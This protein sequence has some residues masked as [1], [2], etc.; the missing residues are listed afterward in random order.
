MTTLIATVLYF[1][2][3]ACAYMAGVA[4]QTQDTQTS[5]FAI[6]LVCLFFG[7]A[8]ALTVWG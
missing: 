5:G 7:L 8:L 6:W 3:L 1:V 4:A 2:A